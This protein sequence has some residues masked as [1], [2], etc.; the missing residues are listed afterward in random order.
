MVVVGVDVIY[1]KKSNMGHQIG[2]N[3]ETGGCYLKVAVRF[4]CKTQGGDSQIRNI[5]LTFK[6]VLWSSYS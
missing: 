1:S 4:N 6:V 5:F 3:L 2:D